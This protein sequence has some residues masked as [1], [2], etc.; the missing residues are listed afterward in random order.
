MFMATT[1]LEGIWVLTTTLER[2]G[3]ATTWD[4]NQHLREIQVL[5]TTLEG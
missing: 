3:M 2:I 4:A 1:T 5:I